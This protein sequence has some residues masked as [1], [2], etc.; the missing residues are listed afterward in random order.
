MSGGLFTSG[1]PKSLTIKETPL[2]KQIAEWLDN[3]AVYNDRL[4]CGKVETRAGY[5]ITLCKART[6]DSFA[7]VRGNI[8][9]IE[10]KLCGKKPTPEQTT[11]HET[12]MNFGAIVIVADS[13]DSFTQQFSAIRVAIEQQARTP[14]FY[15]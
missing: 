12:L 13:F 8:I 9:F 4:N 7:I 5:W 10:T 2:S 14:N 1:K 11:R 15:D 3:R 6:P